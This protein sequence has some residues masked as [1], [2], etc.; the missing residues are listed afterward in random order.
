VAIIGVNNTD[1]ALKMN[2]VKE[3]IVEAK[4]QARYVIVNVHWGVEYKRNSRKAEQDLAHWF[5]DQG[6]TAVIG[7]H[8][9]VVQEMEIYKGAPIFYSLGNFIFDQYFST[10]TQEGVSVGLTLNDG[11]VKDVYVFPFYGVK[12]QVQLMEGER[13]AKFFDW[14]NKN[15]RLGDKKFSDGKVSL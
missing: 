5:V 2:K 10:D 3:A 11:K 4:K 12:S 6:V 8:P 15:S 9:H 7:G 1:H 13:K 14:W